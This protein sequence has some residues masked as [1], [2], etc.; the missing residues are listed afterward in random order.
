MVS[1]GISH[2]LIF[3]EEATVKRCYFELQIEDEEFSVKQ[4]IMGTMGWNMKRI[5]EK[6]SI[7]NKDSVKLRFVSKDLSKENGKLLFDFNLKI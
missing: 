1:W 6:C 2:D 5:E 3:I 4:R 7:D